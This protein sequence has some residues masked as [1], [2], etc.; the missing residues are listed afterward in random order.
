MEEKNVQTSKGSIGLSTILTLIFVVLK[1]THVIDWKWV[2]VLFPII[3]SY[4]FAI[5]IIIFTFL[6][7]LLSDKRLKKIR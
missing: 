2:W 7:V 5:F 3:L 6:M 4:G 1:L